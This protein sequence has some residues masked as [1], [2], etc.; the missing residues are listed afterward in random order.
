M[1]AVRKTSFYQEISERTINCLSKSI[2]NLF[3]QTKAEIMVSPA[4]ARRWFELNYLS[5]IEEEETFF[6]KRRTSL[7]ELDARR[8]TLLTIREDLKKVGS[9]LLKPYENHLFFEILVLDLKR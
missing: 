9:H 8:K 2:I 6:K 3:K 4:F 5:Q 1:S 7:A